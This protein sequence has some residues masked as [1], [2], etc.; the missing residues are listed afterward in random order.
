MQEVRKTGFLHVYIERNGQ[1]MSI[2]AILPANDAV[3]LLFWDGCAE[4]KGYKMDFF[5]RIGIVCD[6][7]PRGKVATYGQLAFL[8]GS[9]RGA[10]Q[11]GRALSRGASEAAHRV[12]NSRGVL[13]GADAFLFENAQKSLLESEGVAVSGD[14]VDL[15]EYGWR[16]DEE[17]EERL[18]A[19]FTEL[20]V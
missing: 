2:R 16:P 5:R 1:R 18:L 8:C 17:E 3:W 9:P 10:R 12:V 7:I 15:R 13:S 6:A 19:L 4:W 14:R 11:A 20:G